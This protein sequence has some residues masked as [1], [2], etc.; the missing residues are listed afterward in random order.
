MKIL[1]LYP[2]PRRTDGQSL[3]GHNLVKGLKE[4]GVEVMSCDRFDDN[5]KQLIYEH[6]KPDVVI[7]IG[8]WADTPAL[9]LHPLKHGMK[10]VPWFNA[11]GWIANYHETLNSLPLLLTTSNWVKSTYIRDGVNGENISACPIG[12][13]PKIFYPVSDND[14]KRKNKRQELGIADDEIMILTAGGDVTSKGAQE[15]FKALAKIGNKFTNWK[16]VLKTLQTFSAM[17]HGKE[18]EK[19]IEELG[20]D[21]SKFIYV[22]DDY[23]PEQMAELIQAC[24]IYAAPS[25]LEGFGM[26][27]L[28]AQAC[29]KPV[30]SI[31]VGGPKEI[32][33][34]G[35]TGFLADIG[36]EIKLEKEWVHTS[37]GFAE[38]KQIEFSHPKTFAYRA[39]IN[40]LAD[41]TLELMAN[42]ELRDKIGAAAA[43]HALENFH[44]KV[45]AKKM[46]N[47]IEENLNIHQ[48]QSS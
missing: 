33:L 9:I 20:L 7:G 21:K 42:P 3:Q 13:D 10:P 17:N 34:H 45:T 40:Q 2:Y 6:F 32:I 14:I 15:M 46:L 30:V 23:S 4:N 37:M 35:K 8:F 39:D 1:V 31:N 18:E 16:Y 26:I 24:D 47:L 27:Q 19:L 11:D 22:R 44:Y 28:E 41:A 25:R 12:F 36:E 29:G 48:T 5:E 38:E 43:N